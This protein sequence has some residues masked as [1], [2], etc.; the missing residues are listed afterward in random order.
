M[1]TALSSWELCRCSFQ[2]VQGGA[3]V[4]HCC[5]SNPVLKQVHLQHHPAPALTQAKATFRMYQGP[6]PGWVH[7]STSP[8]RLQTTQGQPPH[9]KPTTCT[10][11]ESQVGQEPHAVNTTNHTPFGLDHRPPQP[12]SLLAV[13]DSVRA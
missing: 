13:Q 3:T 11:S 7:S 12:S 2:V 10:F 5:H 4:C 6:P 1:S 9:K 8:L